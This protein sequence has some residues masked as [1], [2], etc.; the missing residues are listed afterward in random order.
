MR[1]LRQAL[2]P[3]HCTRCA[4]RPADGGPACTSKC[5]TFAGPLRATASLPGLSQEAA[6]AA[7][8]P[9]RR[10]QVRPA[11]NPRVKVLAILAARRRW[12]QVAE[13]GPQRE[14]KAVLLEA[15]GSPSEDVRAASCMGRVG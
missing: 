6:G 15:L 5:S 12:G 14:L 9:G 7:S 13:P 1:G 8:T 3:A 11:P 4:S 10:G 2:R